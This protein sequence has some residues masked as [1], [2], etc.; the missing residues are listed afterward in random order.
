MAVQAQAGT[1]TAKAEMVDVVSVYPSYEIVVRGEK[2]RL[3]DV[4]GDVQSQR[5]QSRKSYTFKNCRAK[6]LK[7]D[8]D[9][10]KARPN[11]GYGMEWIALDEWKA[12]RKKKD[13]AARNFMLQL[14]NRV[15]DSPPDGRVEL[16]RI[17]HELES[18]VEE[19]FE[20]GV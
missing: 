10:L 20:I 8:F 4:G 18:F 3:V 12:L 9:E 14:K 13:N 16:Q 19:V 17:P 1:N 2:K 7:D 6:M 15:H 11:I 5:T